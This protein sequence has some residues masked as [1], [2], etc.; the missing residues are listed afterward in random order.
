MLGQKVNTAYF[1]GVEVT[2]T[3]SGVSEE[4]TALNFEVSKYK[5]GTNLVPP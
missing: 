3:T 2:A 1:V 5:G 4:F